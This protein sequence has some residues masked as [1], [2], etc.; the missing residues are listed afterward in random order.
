MMFGSSAGTPMRILLNLLLGAGPDK[1]ITETGGELKT[2]EDRTVDGVSCPA[3][4]FDQAEG[5]DIRLV[6]DPKTKLLKGI[7]LVIDPKDL[8][9]GL[10]QGQK[11]SIQTFGWN[12]GAV[13]TKEPKGDLFAYQ[14]PKG[15][16]KV[17]NPED[18][19]K[20]ESPI[21]AL[22]GKPAPDFTLTVLDGE[23]KTKTLSKT[24]LA[25]KVVMIDFWAT[26]CGPC[27]MELPEI[28][29]LIEAYA[30]DKKDILVVALSQDREA[31]DLSHVRKLVEKTLAEKKI[32]LTGTP[33][34]RIGLD[35]TGT[36]G[37]AFQVTGLPTVVL[38][39][40]KGVVQAAH[41]GF[42]DVTKVRENLTKDIDAL[43][44]GKTLAK[45]KG[46]KAASDKN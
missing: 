41:V 27:M 2:D 20:P 7:D 15:V 45:P 11:L 36:V 1:L 38:L 44:A 5:P 24:D 34:G 17:E 13:S 14:A 42:S 10:P 43:L 31:G 18:I 33:I 32:E 46:Q 40:P 37:E 23:D 3:L 35:P 6:I 22:V 16:T 26:W 9:T 8:A 19:V 4:L 12:A 29:K 30:K 21:D 28:Q 39:D 25:G